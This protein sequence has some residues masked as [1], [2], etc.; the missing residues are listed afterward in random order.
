[1]RATKQRYEERRAGSGILKLWSADYLEIESPNGTQ[2]LDCADCPYD[3]GEGI[4]ADDTDEMGAFVESAEIYLEDKRVTSVTRVNNGCMVQWT[5][6]GYMDCTTPVG[7][8]T[9]TE[10]REYFRDELAEYRN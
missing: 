8:S 7:F 2:F 6:P 4:D 9:Y 1:M 5:M 10:A 3:V